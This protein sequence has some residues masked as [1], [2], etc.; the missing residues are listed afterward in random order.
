[1][2]NKVRV[3]YAPS[4]TGHL[5]IGNARTALFNYL[6]AKHH[7]GEFIIRIEDTDLKRNIEGGEQ[8][9][10]ENLQWLN[11]DWGESPQKPGKYG[12]YRQ[13]ERKDIYLPLIEQLLM[14][15]LAYK[16]YCTEEELEEARAAQEARGEMPRYAGT[17]ANLTAEQQAKYE[18]EG[19]DYVIRFRAPRNKSYS[20]ED[21][22]KG[23]ITFESDSVGGDFVILKRDGMPTYNFAVVV[24]DHLM[25]ISH[26]LRG[27]DHIANTPKQLMI[28]EAF[29]WTPPTFGHMTLII[30]SETGKKLSKRDETILQFI[31][32]YRE[33]G[34]LPEAMFNF[35]ALLGWSP[36]GEEE[37]FSQEDLIRM[38]DADRLSKS[39][40]AFDA[41][42]L[43]W[44]NNQYMKKMPLADLV[45]MCHPF[46]V[47]EGLLS[48]NLS[49]DEQAWLEKLVALYQPQM[50]YAA[51]IIDLS[52]MFFDEHPTRDAASQEVL[53]GET[54]PTVLKAFR[55]QMLALEEFDVPSIK[56]AIKAVQKETGVKGKNLF[57]PIRVAV[58]GQMHGPELGDTILLLGKD[59][60]IQHLDEAMNA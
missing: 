19:R 46:F 52:Q 44:I 53:A 6:Y 43:E 34:Y 55:E 35:I 16:C 10:L 23:T 5:H 1:M 29:G 58:S 14:S 50:S 33:L 36:V 28:Y 60:T 39:P 42:K 40:A 22:V 17:C 26:V 18:A 45:E 11:I 41:K 59:K 9:Q 38:F 48:E 4:P 20:F 37:I 3:R 25:E 32:Q 47:K 24:D 51:E 15:N 21:L 13:S 7:D 8:S 12:P 56:Q 2:S 31:E 54:V 49:A 27:D 57:M 30:N